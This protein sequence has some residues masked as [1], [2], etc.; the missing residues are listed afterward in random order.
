MVL[1]PEQ[2]PAPST[3]NQAPPQRHQRGGRRALDARWLA[4]L[5]G[6]GDPGD[7]SE[8]RAHAGIATGVRQFNRGDFFEAHESFE[9]AWRE[10]SYPS[11]LCCMALTK[12]AAGFAHARNA[13]ETGAAR[14]LDDGLRWLAPF[15]PSHAGLD[16]RSLGRSVRRWRDAQRQQRP[17]LRFPRIVRSHP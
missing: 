7:G 6:G 9:A 15:E 16:T 1:Q 10:A 5:E 3:Q 13:N 12:I 8:L 2:R 11:R 17:R 4:H 14:L